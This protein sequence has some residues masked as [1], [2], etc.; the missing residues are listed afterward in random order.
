MHA[1]GPLLESDKQEAWATLFFFASNAAII[2]VEDT[3]QHLCTKLEPRRKHRT[4]TTVPRLVVGYF[5]VLS[6]LALLGPFWNYR[7]L[8]SHWSNLWPVSAPL[9]QPAMVFMGAKG[10]FVLTIGCM[11]KI[12]FKTS[13]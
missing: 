11:L 8:R 1:I 7:M 6:W 10:Y 5:W 9:S 3:L 2:M 13:L 4:Q 12:M